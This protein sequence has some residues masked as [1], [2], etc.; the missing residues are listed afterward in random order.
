MSFVLLAS[1]GLHMVGIPHVHHHGSDT[2]ADS[3]VMIAEYAHT[4]DKKLFI[5]APL[6]VFFFFKIRFVAAQEIRA[7]LYARFYF[8]RQRWFN[9]CTRL[10]R[11]YLIGNAHVL[12]FG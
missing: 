10:S 12:I 2:H 3:R 1:F 8:Y 4:A 7:V 6:L 9:F 5:F 11:L